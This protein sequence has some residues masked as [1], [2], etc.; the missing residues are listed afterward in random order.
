[1]TYPELPDGRRLVGDQVARELGGPLDID[2][3]RKIATPGRPEPALGA[4]A[5]GRSAL[6]LLP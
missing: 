1:M 3:V 5:I 6:P 2:F 4:V